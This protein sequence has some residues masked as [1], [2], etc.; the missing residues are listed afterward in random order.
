MTCALIGHALIGSYWAWFNLGP[1]ECS[2]PR[3]PPETFAHIYMH[4]P[5]Y[6]WKGV[7]K[8]RAKVDSVLHFLKFLDGNPAA[9]AFPDLV[10]LS[11]SEGG[12]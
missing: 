10:A 2:C 8:H 6:V 7:A 9:F 11:L 3:F 4:C 5:L 1:E 12:S